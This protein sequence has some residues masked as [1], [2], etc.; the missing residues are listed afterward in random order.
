MGRI[1][2]YGNETFDL[3]SIMYIDKRDFYNCDEGCYVQIHLL[4]GNEYVLNPDTGITELIKPVIEIGFGKNNHAINFIEAVSEEWE[5][6]LESKEA[7][8]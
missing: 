5:K 3:G 7:Q 2:N 8:T 1:F 6:Y 4:K